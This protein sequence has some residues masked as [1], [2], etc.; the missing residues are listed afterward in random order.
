[1][2][3]TVIVVN[4][5]LFLVFFEFKQRSNKDN[6]LNE[7]FCAIVYCLLLEDDARD[8]GYDYTFF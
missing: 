5:I 2:Q 1:M 3:R 7:H 6:E 4:F 8:N